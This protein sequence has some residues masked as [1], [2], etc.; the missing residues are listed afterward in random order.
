MVNDFHR[1]DRAWAAAIGRMEKNGKDGPNI[2][3]P[4]K[5]NVPIHG[6]ENKTKSRP[7]V[8]AT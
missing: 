3:V 1:Y 8:R 6:N 2:I 5:R 7:H 4:T